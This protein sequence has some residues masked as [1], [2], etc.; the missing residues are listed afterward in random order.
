MERD[1]WDL[2]IQGL[3]FSDLEW[4]EIVSGVAKNRCILK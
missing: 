3:G 4:L 2:L 1:F